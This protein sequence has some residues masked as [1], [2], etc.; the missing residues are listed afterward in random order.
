MVDEK[1]LQINIELLEAQIEQRLKSW[2]E[3]LKNEL[4]VLIDQYMKV[5]DYK[6]YVDGKV[7][8]HQFSA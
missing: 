4:L 6:K 8:S 1:K 5:A 7:D 2:V 3:K